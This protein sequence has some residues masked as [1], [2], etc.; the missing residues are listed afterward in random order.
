M[1]RYE[2]LVDFERKKTVHAA[3]GRQSSECSHHTR[4]VPNHQ[5]HP[6]VQTAMVFMMFARC[7][8]HPSNQGIRPR[9]HFPGCPACT[10]QAL[11]SA[12][13]LQNVTRT[14]AN[15]GS[16]ANRMLLCVRNRPAVMRASRNRTFA[17]LTNSGFAP[18]STK[19]VY[20][21]LPTDTHS[22][23]FQA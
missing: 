8:A 6:L 16:L 18:K 11:R 14:M 5:K 7:F 22:R 19:T 15:H 1:T 3:R 13:H 20:S 4:M 10:Q 17:V 21:R 2:I 9:H 12:K 23:H